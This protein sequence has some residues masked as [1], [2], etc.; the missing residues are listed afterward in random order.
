MKQSNYSFIDGLLIDNAKISKAKGNVHNAFDWDKAAAI[1]REKVKVHPDL[2]A[3]AGL[4]GDW[5]YTGGIIFEDGKPVIDGGTYLQSNWATP[6]MILSWDDEE[7]EEI[8]CF[9]EGNARFNES[10]TW[11][12]I[13]LAILSAEPAKVALNEE[14]KKASYRAMKKMLK[15]KI[16]VASSMAA[17]EEEIKKDPQY[18]KKLFIAKVVKQNIFDTDTLHRLFPKLTGMNN[19]QDDDE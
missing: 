6:T 8:P 4:Q 3:E 2:R 17:L 12:E 13:S 16:D 10:T 7:Q 5:E 14:E 15:A 1:I 9:T 18:I 11:D 19:K